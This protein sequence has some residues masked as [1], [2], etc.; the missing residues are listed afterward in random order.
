[1]ADEREREREREVVAAK[2]LE[3]VGCVS[4]SIRWVARE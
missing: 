3:Q 2:K 1:M 4:L